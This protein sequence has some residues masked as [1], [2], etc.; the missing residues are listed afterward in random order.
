MI[1]VLVIGL[2]YALIPSRILEDELI[3]PFRNQTVE[4]SNVQKRYF[5]WQIALEQIGRRPLLGYGL[6]NIDEALPDE[7]DF[8]H[9]KPA[10]YHSIKDLT[11][12][13]THNL[14]LNLLLWGGVVLVIPFIVLLAILYKSTKSLTLK[15]S[16]SIFLV[17]SF[18]QNL[19]LVHWLFFYILI[20]MIA[21]EAKESI[22]ATIKKKVQLSEK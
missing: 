5:I 6:E 13:N 22:D 7:Y 10:F 12:D 17:W 4:F 9:P 15:V 8:N 19:S 18:F 11:I 21:A 2:F 20:A 1:G 14:F 3:Q 16:L